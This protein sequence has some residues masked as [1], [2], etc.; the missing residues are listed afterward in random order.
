[1]TENKPK[2]KRKPP[3]KTGKRNWD[4]LAYVGVATRI[5]LQGIVGNRS[6][7]SI[8]EKMSGFSYTNLRNAVRKLDK[9]CNPTVYFLTDFANAIGCS[10]EDLL[11]QIGR[12]IDLEHEKEKR[13]KREEDKS[14]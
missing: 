11:S 1:M 7:H 13:K 10:V 8:S 2:K 12:E 6:V 4:D 9:P 3:I 5:V 14:K